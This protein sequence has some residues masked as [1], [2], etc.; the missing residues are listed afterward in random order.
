MRTS[1]RASL[2]FVRSRSCSR[3]FALFFLAALLLPAVVPRASAQVGGP[4]TVK[5]EPVLLVNGS[6]ALFRVSAPAEL[7]SLEGTWLGHALQFRFG[8][9]C[10]CWYALG[11]VDLN[12]KT[13]RY[14]L[15]LQG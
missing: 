13:G 11:G 2:A 7:T 1:C 5:W 10:N 4:W 15:S 14:S 12:T 3:Q 8:Q 9:S 6:P